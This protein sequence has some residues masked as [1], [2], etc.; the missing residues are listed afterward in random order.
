MELFV[1][2]RNTWNHL[3]VWK[4]VINKMYLEIR[5]MHKKY[6]SLNNLQLVIC[7]KTQ[8]NQSTYI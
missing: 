1:L 5:Y 3:I 6:L 4:N 7:Q 8:P 2:D